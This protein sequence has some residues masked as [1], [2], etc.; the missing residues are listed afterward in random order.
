VGA[1]LFSQDDRLLAVRLSD[2]T[3]FQLEIGTASE[4]SARK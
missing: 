4:A 1:K 2:Q 3:L